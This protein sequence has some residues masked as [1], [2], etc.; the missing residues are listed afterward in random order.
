MIYLK[1][2]HILVNIDLK[3]L[4]ELNQAPVKF[5]LFKEALKLE[6]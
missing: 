6:T 2:W 3:N 1:Y 5:H 4:A